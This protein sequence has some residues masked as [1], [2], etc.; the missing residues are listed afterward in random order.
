M[1]LA[2]PAAHLATN[3]IYAMASDFSFTLFVLRDCYS[4][5]GPSFGAHSEK[6]SAVFQTVCL[7]RAFIT[8]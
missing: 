3:K 4:E 7:E 5:S 2:L 8:W 6:Q 1:D